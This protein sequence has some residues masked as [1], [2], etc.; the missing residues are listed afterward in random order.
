MVSDIATDSERLLSIVENLLHLA[1]LQAGVHPN[2]EPQMLDHVVRHEVRGFRKRHPERNI[3]ISDTSPHLVVESDG[4]YLTLLIQNLLSNA[5]KYGG[6][7]PI[8]V[9]VDAED[10]EARVIVRDRGLGIG[11]ATFDELAVAFYRG[12][13]A[14]VVASGVGLGLSLCARIVALMGGRMWA[15]SRPGG[16]STFGFTIPLSPDGLDD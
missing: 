16:G 11:D 2:L 15:T 1:R 13:E 6:S 12:E 4:A 3:A 14:Q 7:S 9:V 10:G 8:E 5:H